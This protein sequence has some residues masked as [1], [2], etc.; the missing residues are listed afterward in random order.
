M[1]LLERAVS[2]YDTWL[3]VQHRLTSTELQ[4][5]TYSFGDLGA[6]FSGFLSVSGSSAE[7]ALLICSVARLAL[8]GIHTL[9]VLLVPA[10]QEAGTHMRD[11]R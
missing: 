2:D 5:N 1:V 7:A 8:R 10:A 6:G 3:I 11:K 4:W 9:D